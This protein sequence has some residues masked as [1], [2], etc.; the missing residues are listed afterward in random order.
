MKSLEA[1]DNYYYIIYHPKL[2]VS[3]KYYDETLKKTHCY[4]EL[5]KIKVG[6]CWIVKKTN[7]TE[8]KII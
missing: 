3:M 2:N 8:R 1:I 6:I 7:I 5:Y 4:V